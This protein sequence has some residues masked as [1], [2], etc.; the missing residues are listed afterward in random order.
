MLPPPTEIAS[1]IGVLAR[2]GLLLPDIIASI[3]RVLFGFFVASSLGVSFGIAMG[4]SKKFFDLVKPILEIIRPIPPIAWIPI[5]LLWFGFG[6]PPAFFLVAVGAFF[7]ILTNSYFGVRSIEKSY[8][9]AAYSLGV[10]GWLLFTDVIFPAALPSIMTGLKVGLGVGWICVITAELVGSQSGLGYMIQ[11]SRAQLQM[12]NVLAGMVIIG[13]VG[14][15][16]SG[17]MVLFEWVFLPWRR[18]GRE[19][20]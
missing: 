13:L 16:L 7:P 19:L 10:R 17:I 1:A 8:I 6:D 11:V 15:V 2:Q 9:Y 4:L 20:H 18:R 12:D 5:A 14:F 3:R